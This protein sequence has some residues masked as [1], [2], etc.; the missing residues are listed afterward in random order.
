[1]WDLETINRMNSEAVR[2]EQA[3]ANP[4]LYAGWITE[5][6]ADTLTADAV[7]EVENRMGASILALQAQVA[8]LTE[9]IEQADPADAAL[10]YEM[11]A[12]RAWAD[13]QDG[14]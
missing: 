11:A 9:R 6:D 8:A 13:F 1:M 4:D 12:E 2:Q 5:E 14:Q 3:E 10:R 7:E